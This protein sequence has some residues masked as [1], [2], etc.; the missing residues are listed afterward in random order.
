[1]NVYVKLEAVS[2]R[3]PDGWLIEGKIVPT[4]KSSLQIL[5]GSRFRMDFLVDDTDSEKE[6]RKSAM[7]LHGNFNSS[8][9]SDVRG[10]Y[11]P[12]LDRVK[13]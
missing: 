6:S 9:R 11:E 2:R 10:K 1:V 5:P 3:T 4:G 7:A 12:A 8:I 13:E